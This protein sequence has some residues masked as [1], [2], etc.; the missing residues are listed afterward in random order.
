MKIDFMIACLLAILCSAA[1]PL[2]AEEPV[3]D[4]DWMV[5]YSESGDRVHTMELTLFPQAE[6][7]PA[8]RHRLLPRT[9][10]QHEGNAA[11]FYLKAMGFF[12]QQP[13]HRNLFEFEDR[14][15]EAAKAEDDETTPAPY[16]WLEMRPDEIPV[17]EVKEYLQLLSF[18]VPLLADAWHRG[19]FSLDRDLSK[20]DSPVSYL[21][22]EIQQMRELVRMQ[23]L[24]FRLAIR[25]SRVDDALDVLRQQLA[26]A[27]H[28][29]QDEFLVATLV[30]FAAAEVTW[31][32]MLYWV[33]HRESPNL[34]WSLA[35]LPKLAVSDASLDNDLNF[36]YLEIPP[37][38]RVDTKSHLP[39]N[40]NWIA[41]KFLEKSEYLAALEAWEMDISKAVSPEYRAAL[42]AAIFASSYPA[43]KRY[44]IKDAQVEQGVV[45]SLPPAQVVLAAI[46][47]NHD[48]HRDDFYKWYSLPLPQVISHPEYQ[49]LESK[50]RE[51]QEQNGVIAMMSNILLPAIRAVRISEGRAQQGAE[52]LRTVEAIRDHAAASGEL[53]KQLEDMRLP[54]PI[55]PF[56]GKPLQYA[57]QQDHAVLTTRAPHLTRRLILKLAP[58]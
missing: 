58:Q 13:A 43:S 37:M 5:S 4:G 1:V 14:A 12:E 29:S 40:F 28:L 20:V 6:P 30:G 46:K 34:Y 41:A 35:A 33:Q 8:L 49:E 50:L 23:S 52:M 31:T 32:D 57:H 17:E 38:L 55:D 11:L 10:D 7:I 45:D 21:L 27:N 48:R 47:H 16:R 26:L 51:D 15:R 25:E 54:P 18:Q 44:L 22:P 39:D 53:P 24:R 42:Y 36:L 19:Q 2:P 56:T 3:R 9:I